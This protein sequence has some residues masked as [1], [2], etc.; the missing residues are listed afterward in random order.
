MAS[1]IQ[2][3]DIKDSLPLEIT[4]GNFKEIMGIM[5]EAI[6]KTNENIR[7]LGKAIL[8][9]DEEINFIRKQIK[10]LAEYQKIVGMELDFIGNA[11]KKISI[12]APK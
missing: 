11:M 7:L 2:V 4:V 1:K 5:A 6:D 8:A 12:I 9:Q 3:V 10:A